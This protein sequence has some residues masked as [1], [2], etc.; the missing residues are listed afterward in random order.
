MMERCP[1][2]KKKEKLI[3]NLFPDGEIAACVM[4]SMNALWAH[5]NEKENANG[6][7]E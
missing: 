3:T 2:C 7:S 4:C 1:F 5:M 6:E